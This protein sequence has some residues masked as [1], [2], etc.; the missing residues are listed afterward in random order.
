MRGYTPQCTEGV[1][2]S[3]RWRVSPW[4]RQTLVP[5]FLKLRDFILRYC[6]G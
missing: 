3:T 1:C 6:D 5:R 4:Y 2:G